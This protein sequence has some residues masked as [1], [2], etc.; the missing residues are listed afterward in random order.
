MK[1]GLWERLLVA[2]VSWR[3]LE[4]LGAESWMVDNANPVCGSHPR[5]RLTA[6]LT[7]LSD[8]IVARNPDV[9]VACGGEAQK[10]AAIWRGPLIGLPHP[11]HYPAAIAYERAKLVLAGLKPDDRWRYSTPRA[12][13]LEMEPMPRHTNQRADYD[14]PVICL[15]HDLKSGKYHPTLYVR[16]PHFSNAHRY[17]LHYTQGYENPS[18][19]AAYAG[20]EWRTLIDYHTDHVI[21]MRLNDIFQWDGD[22]LPDPGPWVFGAET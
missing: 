12:G 17:R 6:D 22:G 14:G 10:I 7:H 13:V 8:L 1:R 18:A 19:A 21:Q 4:T 20:G 15:T 3:R 5:S 9:V 11:A 16:H 2:S